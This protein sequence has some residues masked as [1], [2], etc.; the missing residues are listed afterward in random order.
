MVQRG[1][2]DQAQGICLLLGHGRKLVS[3][4]GDLR[5]R[6]PLI[7]PCTSRGQRFQDKRSHF[8]L[9][10]AVNDERTVDVLMDVEPAGCMPHLGLARFDE[11]VHAPPAPHDTLDVEGGARA[12]DGKE[13]PLRF[14]GRDP[15]EGADLGIGELPSGQG[16]TQKGKGPEGSGHADMFAGSPEVESYSPGQPLRAGA[17]AGVPP[18]PD[19]EVPYERQEPGAGCIQMGSELRDLIAEALELCDAR[20]SG[21]VDWPIR[22]HGGAYAAIWYCPSDWQSCPRGPSPRDPSPSE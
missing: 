12:S 21:H 13:A 17:K 11:P 2:G 4:V 8:G 15:R 5:R 9:E 18:I 20:V 14:W 3:L 19:V 6:P 1:L 10:P 16:V 22:D 7:Q